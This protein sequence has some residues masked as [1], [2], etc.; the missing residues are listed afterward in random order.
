MA[1][2]RSADSVRYPMNPSGHELS[3]GSVAATPGRWL[4]KR[5]QEGWE[6]VGACSCRWCVGKWE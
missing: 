3:G 5:A 2:G 6:R 1:L 4:A